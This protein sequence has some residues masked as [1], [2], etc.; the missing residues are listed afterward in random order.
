MLSK[1][2]SRCQPC[3]W[4]I[5]QPDRLHSVSPVNIRPLLAESLKD[6]V[7]PDVQ[8]DAE[9]G[10]GL[11]EEF[12]DQSL[13]ENSKHTSQHLG[14]CVFTESLTSSGPR[15]HV[16]DLKDEQPGSDEHR[17]S[18]G[19]EGL[20][21]EQNE[22]GM[23]FTITQTPIVENTQELLRNIRGVAIIHLQTVKR[24]FTEASDLELL[25]RLFT[26]M[27]DPLDGKF[28]ETHVANLMATLTYLAEDLGVQE[29]QIQSKIDSFRTVFL[30]VGK[31]R[32]LNGAKEQTDCL[33]EW[34]EAI[35]RYE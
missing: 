16:N 22:G 30:A 2:Q 28:L 3:G 26:D 9:H 7:M 5:P 31:A 11:T 15:L 1:V 17:H 35:H 13:V 10:T 20:D 34:D 19:G 23:E 6:E 29:R 8:S 18:T 21:I 33:R 32:A 24:Y 4:W 12:G 27:K 25:L 14:A